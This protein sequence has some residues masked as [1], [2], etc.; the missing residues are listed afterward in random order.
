MLRGAAIAV[1]V[2]GTVGSFL[3]ALGD[4][5]KALRAARSLW[6]ASGTVTEEEFR[7]FVRS[8]DRET[9]YP[10]LQNI[11]WRE[12][13]RDDAAA[14][15]T[16]A[17]RAHGEPGFTI[18]PAGRR[19]V[20]YVTRYGYPSSL[21]IG[22]DARAVPGILAALEQA[23]DSG[24][25]V[26]SGQTTVDGDQDL[27]AAQRPVAYELIVPVYDTDSP[28]A[29]VAERRRRFRGWASGQFRAGQLLD[30]A[31]D[32]R[33]LNR[34]PVGVEL[35]DE[36]AGGA[37]VV[38]SYPTG[39]H[40]RGPYVREDRLEVAGGSFLLRYAP[41]PGNPVL[42]EQTFPAPL[43]LVI[44]IA[45]SVLVG[46]ML[47]LLAQVGALYR[48]VRRLARTD[49]LTGVANRRAWD[50][51]LPRELARAG[52][53]GQPVC[54]ALLDLDHFKQ[55]NDRHGHQ[56]G[57]RFLKQAAAAWQA[58]VRRSD[59]L[60]RYGGEE[61]A[62]LLPDCGLDDA[63]EIAERLRTAQPEGTCSVG[64]ARWDGHEDVTALVARADRALYAAKEG[65]R[66]RVRADGAVETAAP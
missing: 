60:A 6:L 58:V 14:G 41:L 49:G 54:V 59:L 29:D 7:V 47:W 34:S 24:E 38:A 16:A 11:S 12:V 25:T 33:A 65:G 26:I 20:Y 52:R 21:R 5:E 31:L 43:V 10:G 30:S 51:A 1:L 64:V 39:F 53:S 48:E 35:H 61:F 66:N 18:R 9:R 62:I 36:A 2:L 45:A 8:L 50:E 55:Y 46:A 37:G 40:A 56:A 28:V 3:A 42:T 13:V 22:Q 23:R 4:Y 44:G 19:P 32:T 63:M 27:P 57:D 15:Y 17:A